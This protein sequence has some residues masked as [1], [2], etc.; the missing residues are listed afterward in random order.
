MSTKI[1][2]EM[3]KELMMEKPLS[4]GEEVDRFVSYCNDFYNINTGIYPIATFEQ[5]QD[6]VRYYLTQPNEVEVCF[7][8]MDRER[9]RMILEPDYKMFL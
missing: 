4:P 8:S 3:L 5:I 7:D 1:T 6:A 9:V 2:P